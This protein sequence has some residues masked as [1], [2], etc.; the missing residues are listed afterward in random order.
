MLRFLKIVCLLSVIILNGCCYIYGEKGIIQHRDT[1]YMRAYSIPPLRIPP[2]LAS[3]TIQA[4]YPVSERYY[5]PLKRIDLTP[6]E[7][8][9]PRVYYIA[10]RRRY[11]PQPS[12][13]PTCPRPAQHFA[14]TTHYCD[15]HTRSEGVRSIGSSVGSARF[16]SLNTTP[17]PQN[18]NMTSPANP[19]MQQKVVANNEAQQIKR[20]YFDPYSK[21]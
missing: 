2:C 9:Q 18:K 8:Y 3:S 15:P 20:H 7:L 21:R 16:M 1:D 12:I 13:A 10:P 4:H 19:P 14:A 17:A 5:G 6:P 11:I